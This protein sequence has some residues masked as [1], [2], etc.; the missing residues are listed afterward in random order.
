MDDKTYRLMFCET[1]RQRLIMTSRQY[2]D[3][4][5]GIMNR[6]ISQ[7]WVLSCRPDGVQALRKGPHEVLAPG[8]RAGKGIYA[9][10]IMQM[11]ISL[12]EEENGKGA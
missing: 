2:A 4:A 6:A 7:G 1:P 11:L 5:M 8:P 12:Q 10:F 3:H 9:Q